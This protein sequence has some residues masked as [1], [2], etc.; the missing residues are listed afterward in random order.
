[1]SAGYAI[2]FEP[3]DPVD[4]LDPAIVCASYLSW[5]TV[6]Q[7]RKLV[8]ATQTTVPAD[9]WSSTLGHAEGLCAAWKPMLDMCRRDGLHAVVVPL[10]EA[11]TDLDMTLT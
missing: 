1:M 9:I 7:R 11:L 8:V 6:A 3:R 4:G 10:D 5:D 2:R